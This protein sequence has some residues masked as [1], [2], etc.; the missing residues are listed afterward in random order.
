MSETS[1]STHDNPTMF[2]GALG[3]FF[4]VARDAHCVNIFH[5]GTTHKSWAAPLHTLEVR[6][7][8]TVFGWRGG[9]VLGCAFELSKHVELAEGVRVM[10]DGSEVA[11]QAVAT[12]ST[13]GGAE[14][15]SRTGAFCSPVRRK[16][17]FLE[18]RL[19]RQ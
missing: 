17:T 11:L 16:D 1:L 2:A 19:N 12:A 4:Q 9:R 7:P 8:D 5:W 3:R 13:L 18:R 6:V 10:R 14:A 15:R